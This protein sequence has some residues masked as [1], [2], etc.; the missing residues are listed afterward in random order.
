M[1]MKITRLARAA[2]CGSF[3]ASGFCSAAAACEASPAKARYPK[4]QA[5]SLRSARRE[6]PIG[7]DPNIGPSS[8]EILETRRT[9]QRVAE[10]RPRPDPRRRLDRRSDAGSDA[11]DSDRASWT[12]ASDGSISSGR[13]G[14]PRMRR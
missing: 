13:G 9:E 3:A 2:K 8:I 6:I 4:P 10:N 11:A 1:N 12:S 5:A 14:R 7:C